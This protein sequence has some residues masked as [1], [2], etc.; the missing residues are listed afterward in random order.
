MS[1]VSFYGFRP[2]ARL[3]AWRALLS[4]N[5]KDGC[6]GLPQSARSEQPKAPNSVLITFRNVLGPTVNELLQRAFHLNP[7]TQL[8]V[9]VPK[10]DGSFSD[11]GYATLRN[12]R[13]PYVATGVLQEMP[14]VVKRLNLDAPP[15]FLQMSKQ[16]SH[17]VSDELR[18]EL[19]RSQG[20]TEKCDHGLPPCLQQPVVI[21]VHAR[22]PDAG[23][24]VQSSRSDHCVYM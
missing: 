23:E 7:A 15:A 14:F 18:P 17:L 8:F 6:R 24:V 10:P 13:P 20:R 3:G 16:V 2:R 5:D 22:N 1:E 21:A 19:T 12:G 9:F 11:P 4:E